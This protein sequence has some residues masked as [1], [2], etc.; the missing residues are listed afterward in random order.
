[1]KNKI[2][3]I[4]TSDG[5]LDEHFGHCK[6]FTLFTVSDKLVGATEVV[7]APPHE[8]GKLPHW[9][10]EKGVTDVIAGGMGQGAINIFNSLNI[11]VFVGATKK[12]P[13]NIIEGFLNNTLTLNAN[14]CHH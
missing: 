3:A 1:M 2:I 8:P 4:P 6:S 14:N 13:A 12:S 9:L 7:D 10:S 11:N 5:M